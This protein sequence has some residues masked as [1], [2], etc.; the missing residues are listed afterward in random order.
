MHRE[1]IH[2]HRPAR[3]GMTL[4]EVL[5]VMAIVA[6]LMGLVLPAEQSA[7]DVVRSASC[8]INI[9]EVTES[10]NW[11][12]DN[13]ATGTFPGWAGGSSREQTSVTLT[14]P[15]GNNGGSQLCGHLPAV[16]S[17]FR[18]MDGFYPLNTPAA[19]SSSDNSFGS[20]HPGGGG[21]LFADGSVRFVTD[22]VDPDLYQAWGTRAGGEVASGGY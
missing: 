15:N 7:R 13:S 17:V 14:G 21:F 22:A 5:V 20:R 6:L 18:F 2:R 4:V 10:L 1:T 3:P 8:G 12:A 19:V 16:G 11:S 9:G